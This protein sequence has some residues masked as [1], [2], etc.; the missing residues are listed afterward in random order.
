MDTNTITMKTHTQPGQSS[1][2]TICDIPDGFTTR[3]GPDGQRYLVPVFMVPALDQAFALYRTK[4]ELGVCNAPAGVSLRF[5][6][7]NRRWRLTGSEIL[8]TDVFGAKIIRSV[9]TTIIGADML[10]S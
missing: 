4:A 7:L 2:T 9:G 5:F 10:Y 6:I 8:S 3:T 1:S